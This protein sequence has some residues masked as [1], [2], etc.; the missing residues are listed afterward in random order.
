MTMSLPAELPEGDGLSE[1]SEGDGRTG[2]P[3]DLKV[4]LGA[5]FVL[6]IL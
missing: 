5:S 1:D 6:V 2:V 3:L 4:L